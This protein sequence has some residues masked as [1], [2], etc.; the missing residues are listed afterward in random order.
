MTKDNTELRQAILKTGKVSKGRL[1]YSQEMYDS[2]FVGKL[3]CKSQ[4]L[5][6]IGIDDLMQLIADHDTKLEQELL[7]EFVARGAE[8]RFCEQIIKS[9]FHGTEE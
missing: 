5:V 6:E 7:A 2:G 1:T 9:V 4:D 8:K 3:M